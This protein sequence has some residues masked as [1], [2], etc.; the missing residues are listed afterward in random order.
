MKC[1][2][3]KEVSMRK[4]SEFQHFGQKE[5][6]ILRN[7]QETRNG[8]RQTQEVSV[9]KATDFQLPRRDRRRGL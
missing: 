7:M 8:Q 6:D 1:K 4:A 9:R 3:A 5:T 2:Y